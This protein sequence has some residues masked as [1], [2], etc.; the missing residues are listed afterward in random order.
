MQQR[1]EALESDRKA[2]DEANW[3]GLVKMYETMKPRDA[4]AIFNDLDLPVL[5]PVL[6]RMKET[7]AASVLA[8]MQPERA[9][10]VTAELA[11]LRT[12]S[13]TPATPALTQ[14]KR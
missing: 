9:R 14:E 8:A 13:I 11:Q 3:R 4:A 2:H 10:Q 7:K 1:L 6:D 5:L 12:R